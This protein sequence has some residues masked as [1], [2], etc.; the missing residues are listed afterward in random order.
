MK[1]LRTKSIFSAVLFLLTALVFSS[2]GVRT[3]VVW[4]EG[5]KDPATGRAIHMLRVVNAPEGADW[6]IWLTSNHIR[7]GETVE[8]TQGEISLFHGCLY[9]MTPYARE[10]KD[11]VVTYNDSP[12]QRHSWAPEGFIL[13]H[14]GRMTP[15]KVTYEFLPSENVPAPPSPN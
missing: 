7:T 12:L 13:E 11:L 9:Y 14:N 8:G 6:K 3:S 5:E 2:C 1:L 4:T 10:G 15:L